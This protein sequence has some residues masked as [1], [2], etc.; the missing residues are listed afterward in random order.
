MERKKI[1]F[2]LT[3]ANNAADRFAAKAI[4]STPQGERGKLWRSCLLTGLAF[5]KQD[6]RLPG[7]I[8]EL[9]D[10]K[11]ELDDILNII[12]AIYPNKIESLKN[13]I[14]AEA[15]ASSYETATNKKVEDDKNET[16]NNALTLFKID[17]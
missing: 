15:K 14:V 1:S 6:V 5:S 11:T 7:L 13:K 12:G 8:A 3:P 16:K 10:E 9:L 2:Y 17:K 4:D